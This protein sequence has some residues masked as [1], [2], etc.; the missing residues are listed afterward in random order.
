MNQAHSLKNYLKKLMKFFHG[1]LIFEELK[2]L[3][4]IN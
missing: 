3:A 1:K 4:S 2:K